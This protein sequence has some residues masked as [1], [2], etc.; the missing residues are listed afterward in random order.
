M[1]VS[2]QQ[3]LIN[4]SSA[5]EN[6]VGDFVFTGFENLEN[7]TGGLTLTTNQQFDFAASNDG[8]GVVFAA[9]GMRLAFDP[10]GDLVLVS[11]GNGLIGGT[12]KARNVDLTLAG[13][14]DIESDIDS[15]SLRTSGGNID[16]AILAQHDLQIG[17]INVGRGNVLLTTASA[18][19]AA[20]G[21]LGV[22]TVA[23]TEAFGNT[24][25]VAGNIQLGTAQRRWGNVGTETKP[26]FMD[27]SQSVN[28]VAFSY[29][30][31]IF[32]GQQP[33]FT[34]TGDK[35]ESIAGAQTSQGLKSAVQNPVDDIAQ[36]DPGIFSEVTPYSLGVDP[37]N[38]PE[39]RLQSGELVPLDESEEEKRRREAA[40]AVG[41]N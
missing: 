12:L 2:D 10:S 23:P 5:I 19:A 21:G 27:A 25:I 33:D 35:L 28:I 41:G 37:L 39:V 6:Q 16:V 9:D 8:A 24:N 4:G 18:D 34:A 14:L 29:Y 20:T 7:T 17:Q 1:H 22:L 38:L 30:E 32:V 26:L 11:S 36:L 31:P 3:W 40:A 13:D 15:L